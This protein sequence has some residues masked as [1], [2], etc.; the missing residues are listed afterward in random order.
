MALWYDPA[1]IGAATGS[2]PLPLLCLDVIKETVVVAFNCQFSLSAALFGPVGCCKGGGHLVRKQ[3]S[4][5]LDRHAS[6]YLANS[7]SWV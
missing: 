4:E 1:S 5:L 3:V 6:G 2:R 7:K